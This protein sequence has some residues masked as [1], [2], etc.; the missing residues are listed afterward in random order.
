VR[1]RWAAAIVVIALPIALGLWWLTL[2]FSLAGMTPRTLTGAAS[3]HARDMF[4]D[5]RRGAMNIATLFQFLRDEMMAYL[6]QFDTSEPVADEKT[7]P[8]SF[9]TLPL[10]P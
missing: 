6:R 7:N 5:I 8:P 4:A 1:R 3:D 10:A 9:Y 2:Q